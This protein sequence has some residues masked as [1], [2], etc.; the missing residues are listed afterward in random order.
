MNNPTYRHIGDHTETVQV[1]YDPGYITYK[2]LLEIFWRSHRPTGQSSRRQYLNAV[3]YHHESQRKAALASKTEWQQK[4]GADIQIEVAPLRSFTM[5][6]AH[7]QKYILKRNA[8]LKEE[9]VRIYPHHADFVD[10][11]A[12]ARLNGYA[13]GNGSRHRLLQELDRLGLSPSGQKTLLGMVQR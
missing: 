2:E 7:H 9:M 3:F 12:V 11:T 1:D 5:A 10:S 8:V 13:G 6:E 4:L